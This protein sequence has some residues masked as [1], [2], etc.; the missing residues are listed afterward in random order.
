MP[1]LNLKLQR[2]G[3]AGPFKV[4]VGS[5]TRVIVEMPRFETVILDD[6]NAPIPNVLVRIEFASGH[7]EERVSDSNGRVAVRHAFPNEEVSVTLP[8]L[9]GALWD[10]EPRTGEEER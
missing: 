4:A 6:L 7:V 10:I 1:E 2:G 8:K 3:R 9:D 5:T